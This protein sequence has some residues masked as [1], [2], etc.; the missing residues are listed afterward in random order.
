M[1]RDAK[2]VLHGKAGRFLPQSAIDKAT[3]LLRKRR[4]GAKLSY[5]AIA[6]Q[7]GV[8]HASTVK[9]WETKSMTERNRLLRTAQRG[10]ARALTDEEEEVAFGWHMYRCG[11]YL[12]TSTEAF[13]RFIGKMK[14]KPPSVKWA[15]QFRRRH[16]LSSRLVQP[17]PDR[18]L[19]E[20][21]ARESVEFL[22]ELRAL[23]KEKGQFLFVDAI[24]LGKPT[25]G[26]RQVAPKGRYDEQ[27]QSA[28]RPYY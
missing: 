28:K 17:T 18:I 7:V 23:D 11:Q 4:A 2:R 20:K 26:T 22:E 5:Q 8:L 13:L 15:W 27:A 3:R 12:D 19:S 1:P 14:G 16:G 25:K 24:T 9:R 10:P 6:D 21:G